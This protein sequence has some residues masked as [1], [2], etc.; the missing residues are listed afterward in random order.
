MNMDDLLKIFSAMRKEYDR[1]M[2]EVDNL[3]YLNIGDISEMINLHNDI[4]Q[5][6]RKGQI[7][8]HYAVIASVS[9]RKVQVSQIIDL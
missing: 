3:T 5:M 9:A 4:A 8:L 6:I 1:R 2:T 7:A